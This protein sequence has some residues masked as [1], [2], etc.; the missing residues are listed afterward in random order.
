MIVKEMNG[1]V[2]KDG[3]EMSYV[4]EFKD[5]KFNQLTERDVKGPNLIG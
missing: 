4:S 3:K 2:A 1:T 5:W